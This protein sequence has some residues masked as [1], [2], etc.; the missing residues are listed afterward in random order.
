[1]KHERPKP[2]EYDPRF[3]AYVARVRD[4]DLPGHLAR[5]GNRTATLLAG[6][7]EEQGD[8]AYAA[9]KWTVK[10]VVQ[11]LADGERLFCY[12]AMCIA[13]GDEQELPGFDEER[14]AANDGSAARSL[15]AIAADFAAVRAATLPLFAGFDEDAWTR[16]GVANGAPITVRALLWLIAGHELHHLAVLEERYGIVSR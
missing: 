13:R 5:Q 8:Y 10:R 14:Y 11:H 12:R 15:A 4:H 2:D 6:L 9:G 16:R 7:T 3:E 1:V